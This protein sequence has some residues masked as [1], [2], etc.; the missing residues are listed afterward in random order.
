ASDMPG[1]L[2]AAEIT[3]E[4]LFE[5]L[6]EEIPHALSVETESW[7]ERPDGSVRIGQVVH[8]RRE[9]HKPIVLGKGGA[10]IKAVGESSRRALTEILEREV[11][12]FLHVRVSER[13]D[14]EADFYRLWGLDPKA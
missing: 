2:L 1:K 4:K 11:H 6:H 3:R 13:W 7:E 9:N 5:R 8:L 12:L 14:E 10:Q